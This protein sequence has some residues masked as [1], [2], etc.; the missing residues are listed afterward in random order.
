MRTQTRVRRRVVVRGVVQGV[1]FRPH[2]Y[3]L[4]SSLHLGGA[5]WNNAAGVVIE[6]EGPGH[7]VDAFV[8]RLQAEPPPLAH[9]SAVVVED[10][11][12]VGGTGFTIR[13]SEQAEGRTFVSPDVTI[14]DDCVAELG[15]PADRRFRHPFITC[16]NCGP[17]YTIT[18]DLPYDRATTTMA[19]FAMCDA[20]AR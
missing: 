18:T 20:C 12:P 13:P 17:R 6:V 1:G 11:E 5:V 15:D 19:A 9:L 7:A 10:V 4:A 3:A 2:V 14:C 16:T 8:D